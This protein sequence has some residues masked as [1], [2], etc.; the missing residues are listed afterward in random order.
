MTHA[1]TPSRSSWSSGGQT[2][3]WASGWRE[4]SIRPGLL[5]PSFTGSARLLSAR[6]A[7]GTVSGR[8]DSNERHRPGVLGSRGAADCS[9]QCKRHENT[10]NETE[11]VRHAAV[12]DSPG[13][14]DRCVCRL[15]WHGVPCH[16]A[17]ESRSR[18]RAR[19]LRRCGPLCSETFSFPSLLLNSSGVKRWALE[20]K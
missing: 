19:G 16:R 9:S 12:T 13:A 3:P 8:G 10:I 1:T 17:G 5:G 7:P 18:T 4:G 14:R 20:S 11:G 2:T 15:G 6:C